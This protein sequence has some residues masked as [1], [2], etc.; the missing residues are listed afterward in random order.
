MP[1]ICE[2]FGIKIRMF[3]NDHEPIH[4]HAEYGGLN[5]KFDI[6][7]NMIAGDIRAGGALRRIREWALLHEVE[8]RNN[9]Q[10]ILTGRTLDRIDPL[11]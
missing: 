3:Y 6:H 8:I 2:F 4:F 11:P 9:W 7:G 5:G 10:K 1:I